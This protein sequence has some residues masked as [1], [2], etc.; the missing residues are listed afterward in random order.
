MQSPRRAL[1]Q[2]AADFVFERG[3]LARERRLRKAKAC[4]RFAQA[5]VFNDSKKERIK[6]RFNDAQGMRS[7]QG[8]SRDAQ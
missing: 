2:A 4:R 8:A 3:D 7:A 5:A 6:S 1:E